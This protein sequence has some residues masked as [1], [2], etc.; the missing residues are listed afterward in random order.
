MTKHS[1]LHLSLAPPLKKTASYLLKRS[2]L[3][4]GEVDSQLLRRPLS[5]H[6]SERARRG[7]PCGRGSPSSSPTR[8]CHFSSLTPPPQRCWSSMMLPREAPPSTPHQYSTFPRSWSPPKHRRYPSY[9]RLRQGH[10]CLHPKH[11][12]SHSSPLKEVTKRLCLR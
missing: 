10:H 11:G 1:S 2:H 4:N 9:T 12:V 6:E 8:G 3:R 7:F 5:H